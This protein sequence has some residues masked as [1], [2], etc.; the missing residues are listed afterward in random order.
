MRSAV[1]DSTATKASKSKKVLVLIKGLT[2]NAFS[3]NI[4]LSSNKES[5]TAKASESE[6]ELTR[7][8]EFTSSKAS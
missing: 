2:V 6:G 3:N 8:K 4:N 1:K 5:T 7:V